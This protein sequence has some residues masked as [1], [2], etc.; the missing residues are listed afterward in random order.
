[1]NLPNK[2]TL[3]RVFLAITVLFILIF[4]FHEVGFSWPRYLIAGRI[5][6]DLRYIVCGVLFVIAAITDYLDG[7]IARTRNIVTNFGK[8]M[9][10]IADKI[11]VN[12]LLIILAFDGFLPVI[13]PV[14]VITRDIIT[15]SIKSLAGSKG[16]TVPASLLGKI[17]TIFMLVGIS[18]VLFYNFPASLLGTGFALGNYLIFIATVLSVF[19]GV[20]YY[21]ANKKFIYDSDI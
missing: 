7:Y 15:D 6:V 13:I 9:D 4:P 3:A 11:L 2:I 8:V 19:S 18:L 12:G 16:S 1:M 17:K 14:V 20:Q 10:A 21:Q 5:L